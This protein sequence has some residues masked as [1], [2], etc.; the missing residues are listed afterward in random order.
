MRR[1]RRVL[2]GISVLLL[3]C[4]VVAGAQEERI[5]SLSP[6]VTELVCQLGQGRL[7]VGRSEVC[8]YPEE[9]KALPAVGRYADPNLEKLVR[10]RPTL[11]LT[12]D[13]RAPRVGSVLKKLGARLIV[14]QCRNVKEYREWVEL[15][16]N[17]LDC[18]REAAAELARF[19][20]EIAGLRE[21][22]PLS[23]SLLWVVSDSPLL[24]G[25]RNSLLSE[26]SQLAG[27]RN[28]GDIC[29][30]AYYR[31]SREALLKNPPDVII[32]ANSGASPQSGDNF[33]GEL[34]A[35]KKRRILRYLHE[36]T[37]MRP[38]PRLPEGIRKLRCEAEELMK[39]EVDDAS[40]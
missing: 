2:C 5:V 15:L 9:V 6:A 11:V 34:T 16:G 37:V 40:R 17:E 36:D 22:E 13:L 7:L 38:G 3:F 1:I 10:L 24:T 14:K 20:R 21:L 26:V 18:Q 8:N 12:N 27:M 19:D 32:W 29:D 35:V 28:A 4:A 31:M 33:W 39:R 25:G 23:L 30:L